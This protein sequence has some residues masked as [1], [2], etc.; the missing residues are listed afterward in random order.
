MGLIGI[1]PDRKRGK[2]L[3]AS[4]YNGFLK[5]DGSK[6][7][8]RVRTDTTDRKAVADMALTQIEELR[9]AWDR[10]KEGNT[11]EKAELPDM[12]LNQPM[13]EWLLA[14]EKQFI[15]L[16]PV[17]RKTNE[18]HVAVLRS[19]REY[20][21][22]L[23]NRRPDEYTRDDC[24]R[25]LDA[26]M[27]DW[28]PETGTPDQSLR[29]LRAVLGMIPTFPAE[30]IDMFRP[31]KGRR[32]RKVDRVL[33]PSERLILWKYQKTAPLDK[34]GIIL[35]A[36]ISFMQPVDIAWTRV[37]DLKQ[38]RDRMS[39]RQRIKTKEGFG[40]ILVADIIAWIEE[41][42]AKD[43]Q[44]VY[45][46]P[47]CVF[48]AEEL[49][50]PNI[51]QTPLSPE[52]ELLRKESASKAASKLFKAV[53]GEC[54]IQR[55]G[56][57]LKSYR[58]TNAAM[59]HAAGFPDYVLMD[60]MGLKELENLKRYLHA[61]SEQLE[62]L[63]RFLLDLHSAPPKRSILCLVQLFEEIQGEMR[64]LEQRLNSSQQ[65]SEKRILGRMEYD[66]GLLMQFLRRLHVDQHVFQEKVLQRL[67]AIEQKHSDPII[68]SMTFSASVNISSQTS[69]DLSWSQG[70]HQTEP[71]LA[72]LVSAFP[73]LVIV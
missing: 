10:A 2:K 15:S 55:P 73:N 34:K 7:T 49:K 24:K 39:R 44:A 66:L 19:F 32:A 46:F 68:T 13:R 38:L 43:P 35:L 42:L 3:A 70:S 23:V 65:E 29:N 11:T 26:L 62:A 18:N 21:G 53:L 37:S 31:P 27:E 6:A 8:K 14:L 17:R 54:E 1:Y 45:A 63:S 67:D 58:H 61:G 59:A 9:A 30:L 36:A 56:L 4:F 57:S 40:T 72:S 51:N 60:A 48:T 64:A 28:D 20:S 12:L 5:P 47:S 52:E 71:T 22:D 25:I 33:S 41:L 16:P 50:D 69:Q